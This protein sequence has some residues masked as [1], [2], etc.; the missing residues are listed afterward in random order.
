M[1]PDKVAVYNRLLAECLKHWQKICQCLLDAAEPVAQVVC[2]SLH[3][4]DQRRHVIKH[5]HRN[6][7]TRLLLCKL[8]QRDVIRQDF[9]SNL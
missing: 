9:V 8:R 4:I 7:L 1:V 3:L 2:K 5:D 6:Q